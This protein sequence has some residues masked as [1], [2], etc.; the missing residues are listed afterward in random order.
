[1]CDVGSAVHAHIAWNSL[2]IPVVSFCTLMIIKWHWTK[3][4]NCLFFKSSILI[5]YNSKHPF[6]Y[7]PPSML[8][9]KWLL[10]NKVLILMVSAQKM[11]D[12]KVGLLFRQSKYICLWLWICY[13]WVASN[14]LT[15][16]L[17]TELKS[18]FWISL[19]WC[20]PLH[21]LFKSWR[22]LLLR[23]RYFLQHFSFRPTQFTSFFQSKRS[24]YTSMQ[25]N[26][27]VSNKTLAGWQPQEVV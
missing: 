17:G 12:N 18:G 11:L 27:S 23:S 13:A 8:P 14:T 7:H 20:W 19:L 21:A 5:F 16:A 26:L 24:H 6:Q 25:K 10:K 2:L 3:S 4:H 1:M 15:D 9:V 22:F